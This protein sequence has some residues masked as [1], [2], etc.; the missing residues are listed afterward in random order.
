MQTEK[1]LSPMVNYRKYC[2]RE[3]KERNQKIE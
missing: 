2:E 3:K 1:Y